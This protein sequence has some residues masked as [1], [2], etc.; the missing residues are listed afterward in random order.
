M[1]EMVIRLVVAI[2]TTLKAAGGR[3]S[4][5]PFFLGAAVDILGAFTV[6]L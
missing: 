2:A 1:A 5:Y 4:F 6:F 3:L